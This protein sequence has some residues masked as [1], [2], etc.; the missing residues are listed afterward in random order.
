M[1]QIVLTSQ[2]CCEGDGSSLPVQGLLWNRGPAVQQTYG[3]SPGSF[4]TILRHGASC[5]QYLRGGRFQWSPC[6]CPHI[7]GP[8][9]LPSSYYECPSSLALLPSASQMIFI[10]PGHLLLEAFPDDFSPYQQCPLPT[11]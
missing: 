8:P 7:S 3:G 2:N 1:E 10:L 11:W 9:L 4:P 6:W 5:K